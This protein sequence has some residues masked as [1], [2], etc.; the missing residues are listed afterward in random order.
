MVLVMNSI[1]KVVHS[2]TNAD[3][4]VEPDIFAK[5]TWLCGELLD[6]SR[7]FREATIKLDSARAAQSVQGMRSAHVDIQ[8]ISDQLAMLHPSMEV[9][10]ANEQKRME[11]A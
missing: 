6:L 5:T 3:A 8:T 7:R 9:A 10:L 4:L 11:R 2:A 1:L